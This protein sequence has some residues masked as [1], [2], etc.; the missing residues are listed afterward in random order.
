MLS[1]ELDRIRHQLRDLPASIGEQI[2]RLSAQFQEVGD[3]LLR[4]SHEL[5][6]TRLDQLG[7]EESI[8]S[9]CDDM[10]K[11][12]ALVIDFQSAMVGT[13][14]PAAALCLYRVTQEALHNVIRHSQAT[15]VTVSV[16][17][18]STTAWLT[19][20]DNGVGFDVTLARAKSALGLISM[21]ERTRLL[22]GHFSLATQPGGGTR[23][24]VTVPLT[25]ANPE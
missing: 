14:D 8:R 21:R 15:H 7:L 22:Q 24:E 13:V 6:P 19:V 3:V 5:H 16:S 23:V 10:A 11:S 1:I 4:L 20:T 25:A 18:T 12:R 9:V 2:V 17:C